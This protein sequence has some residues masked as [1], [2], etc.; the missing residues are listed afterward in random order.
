MLGALTDGVHRA[1]MGDRRDRRRARTHRHGPVQPRH[2]RG[3]R[4]LRRPHPARRAHRD[5]P[6]ACASELQGRRARAISGA[7]TSRPTSRCA[8]TPTSHGTRRPTRRSGSWSGSGATRWCGTARGRA[9]MARRRRSPV[10]SGATSALDASCCR[11][12][13]RAAAWMGDVE[14]ATA[15]RR[16]DERTFDRSRT[17][18]ASR[19]WVPPGP[20]PPPDHSPVLV[21]C[22]YRVHTRSRRAV[23][24]PWRRGCCTTPAGSDIEARAPA[25]RSWP[26]NAKAN[27]FPRGRHTPPRSTSDQ[28]AGLVDATDRFER[29]GALLFAAES[30]TEATHALQ[31]ERDQR[32]AAAMRSRAAR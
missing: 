21:H 12:W 16:R 25:S 19:C 23:T 6:S 24:A 31:R 32:A 10:R 28:A 11:S 8:A 29:I 27:S 18:P 17:C 22:C 1:G 7:S 30:A 2:R 3:R 4:C 13:P 26:S 15:A 5:G 14:R 9:A 20:Q